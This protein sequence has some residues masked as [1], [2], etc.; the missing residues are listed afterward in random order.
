MADVC[1]KD[2][3]LAT[4]RPKLLRLERAPWGM[5][6]NSR[7][8]GICGEGRRITRSG[9]R[10]RD[11]GRGVCGVRRHGGRVTIRALALVLGGSMRVDSAGVRAR[12]R[13]AEPGPR[14][15]ARCVCD[16][17]MHVIVTW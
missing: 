14:G 5:A 8:D 15:R 1:P 7:C 2:G 4:G 16:L 9:V 6:G 10:A 3:A 13:D 12:E 17:V 11:R